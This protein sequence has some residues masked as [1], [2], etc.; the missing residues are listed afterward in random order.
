ML[1]VFLYLFVSLECLG[2][3]DNLV[4]FFSL[5]TP[6]LGMLSSINRLRL[7]FNVS[8]PGDCAVNNK[9]I[10]ILTQS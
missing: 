8:H 5:P 6:S 7:F 3:L 1:Y 4:F 9:L 10:L 2:V